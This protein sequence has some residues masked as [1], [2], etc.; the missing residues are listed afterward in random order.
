MSILSMSVDEF[1]AALA[2]GEA[3]PGGGAA[4]SLAG[5][6]A[7]SLGAMCANCALARREDAELARLL[8]EA[9]ALRGDFLN[10]AECDG[11]TYRIYAALRKAAK[12]DP[13]LAPSLEEGLLAASQPPVD[14][15]RFACC[16]VDLLERMAP[17]ANK[18]LA[19][20]LAVAAALARAA[21]SAAAV[22]LR[23]N[24]AQMENR[25]TAEL[26]LGEAE[27]RLSRYIPRADAL[28]DAVY[29]RCGEEE[30]R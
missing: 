11:E 19:A 22:T 13:T 16:A 4:A 18:A 6:L 26:L 27:E 10:L 23:A 2:S 21:L 24:T 25:Q 20:D 15:L 29:V 12:A 3:A 17:R 9:E 7:A 1:T 28:Y 14:T 5:A 8:A 30:R